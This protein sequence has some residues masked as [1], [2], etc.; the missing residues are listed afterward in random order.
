M[1]NILTVIVNFPTI[2]FST[3]NIYDSKKSAKQRKLIRFAQIYPTL[4]FDKSQISNSQ[5][6]FNFFSLIF[7]KYEWIKCSI[8]YTYLFKIKRNSYVLTT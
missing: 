7:S 8:F 6:I 5:N 3:P 2:K 4:N 1:W